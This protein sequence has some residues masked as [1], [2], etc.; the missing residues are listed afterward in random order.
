MGKLT[1]PSSGSVY[2]DTNALIYLVERIEPYLTASAPI[3]DA[4][5][6]SG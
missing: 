6:N 5:E 3:R 1:L 4:G 2:V